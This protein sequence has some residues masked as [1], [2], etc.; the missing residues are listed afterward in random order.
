MA[1]KI[2]KE[3]LEFWRIWEKDINL[4]DE[5][6]P[7]GAS[8]HDI[9]YGLQATQNFSLLDKICQ[10]CSTSSDKAF[11]T[12]SLIM[13]GYRDEVTAFDYG[14]ALTGPYGMAI[15]GDDGEA[16]AKDYGIAIAGSFGTAIASKGKLAI[17]GS[18]GTAKVGT[19]GVAKAG[20]NGQ[21]IAGWTGI[22]ISG[23]NGL[24][25]VVGNHGYAITGEEGMAIAEHCGVVSAGYH[26]KILIKNRDF[27]LNFR[28]VGT[29]GKDGLKPNVFYEL[30]SESKFIE[31]YP[32]SETK[33]VLSLTDEELVEWAIVRTRPLE[34]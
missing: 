26:G 8:L 23:K 32:D 1:Q 20:E 33:E 34:D 21:A 19:S 14:T 25:I 18:C 10:R 31:H 4:F 6:F 9:F 3:I 24:S 29:I 16:I 28:T 7:Q 12:Q 5:I 22:A 11:L 27:N 17:A 30:N 15:T 13:G 2:T